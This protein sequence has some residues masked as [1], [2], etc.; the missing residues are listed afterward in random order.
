[1]AACQSPPPS[2]RTRHQTVISGRKRAASPSPLPASDQKLA[3]I[4]GIKRQRLVRFL[5]LRTNAS[6]LSDVSAT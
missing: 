3:G 4:L 1:M 5:S 6:L 2:W